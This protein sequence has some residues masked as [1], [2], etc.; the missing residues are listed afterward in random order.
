MCVLILFSSKEVFQFVNQMCVSCHFVRKAE[1]DVFAVFYQ[2]IP[3]DF[4]HVQRPQPSWQDDV[5]T[6]M[7]QTESQA[8]IEKCGVA[9][10]L[11]VGKCSREGSLLF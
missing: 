5:V 9:R 11:V 4:H 6:N 8:V 1:N 2:D 10:G 7:R 3:E